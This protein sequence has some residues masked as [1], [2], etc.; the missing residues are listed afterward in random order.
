MAA[1]EPGGRVDAARRRPRRTA[2][3]ARRGRPASSATSHTETASVVRR[4]RRGPRGPRPAAGRTPPATSASSPTRSWATTVT[5]DALLGVPLD[6][7]CATVA[8]RRARGS[9]EL[10]RGRRPRAQRRRPGG[11]AP[12]RPRS[13]TSPARQ[14]DQAFGEVARA[15]ASVSATQ[16]R[17]RLGVA[18]ALRR[19][20]STV[21]GSSGSRVVAVSASSRCQRTRRADGGRRPRRRSPSGSRWRGRSAPRRRCARS[22]RPCRCRAAARP[23]SARRAARRR[24][25][26]DEASMQVSTTWRSTVNRWTGE[27]CGQQP[28]PLPLRQHRGPAPRSPRAS[29]RPPSSPRPDAEQPDQ[30]LPGR[31]RATGRAAAPPRGPGGRPWPARARRRARRPRPRRAAAAAGPAPGRRPRVEHHLAAARARARARSASG[32][33]SAAAADRGR[34]GQH[35]VHP[36]PGQ[37][38]EVGD[39]G[40]PARGRAP[41]RHR[42]SVEAEPGGE[43]APTPPARPGRSRDRRRRAARRGR[44][45]A[46]AGDRS[47]STCGTSTSQ[48]A[49][50]ALSTVASRSPPS[51]SFRSGTASVGEL[52]DAA[53]AG[54]R[55][56]SRSA[57]SRS[58]ARRGATASASSLRSRSV[59]LGSP[60]R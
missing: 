44:R 26:S 43:V 9:V 25:I 12:A 35:G 33:A 46:P 50:S 6:A 60:A 14:A 31:G 17:G 5:R 59:R 36:A 13:A 54:S 38:G 55:T 51:A 2:A 37:P 40:G 27:A 21:A 7:A 47:R 41:A 8:R 29:P 39:R 20:A 18:E 10:R 1:P 49:T 22:A 16:Q 58:R 45:A 4:P 23:P 53:R 52:A 24:R 30:Q 34:P 19:P 28:D 57:G 11:D 32:P 56:S 3:G 48:V 42:S 15:S